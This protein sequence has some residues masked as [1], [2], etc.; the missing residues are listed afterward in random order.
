MEGAHAPAPG[1]G[2][3]AYILLPPKYACGAP[4]PGASRC[5]ITPSMAF[6]TTTLLNMIHVPL[7]IMPYVVSE[8]LNAKVLHLRAAPARPPPLDLA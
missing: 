4:P 2:A 1:A 5:A 8:L 7:M 6:T 3:A